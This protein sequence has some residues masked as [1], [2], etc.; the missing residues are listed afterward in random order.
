MR[1]CG[2][3]R[4]LAGAAGAPPC[5]REKRSGESTAHRARCGCREL[6]VSYDVYWCGTVGVARDLS[7]RECPGLP[8]PVL[9]VGP[10]PA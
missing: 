5:E 4:E 2:V 1:V 6:T 8:V 3:W 10:M 7:R 9:R